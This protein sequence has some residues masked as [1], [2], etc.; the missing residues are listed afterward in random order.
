MVRRARYKGMRAGE[1]VLPRH[2]L[3]H[4][5]PALLGNAVELALILKA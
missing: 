3:Y 4:S 5:G 1:L 2:R